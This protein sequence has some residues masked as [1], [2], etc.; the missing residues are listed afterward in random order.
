MWKK[1][2]NTLQ[3]ACRIPL[4]VKGLPQKLCSHCKQACGA[5]AGPQSPLLPPAEDSQTL[6]LVQKASD[7]PFDTSCTRKQTQLFLE[8][9]KSFHTAT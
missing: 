8:F 3:A 4:P 9:S 6:T 2:G 7:E 1:D 5:T